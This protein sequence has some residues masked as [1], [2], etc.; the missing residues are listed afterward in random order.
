MR[1]SAALLRP[2]LVGLRHRATYASEHRAESWKPPPGFV[3]MEADDSFD[4][5]SFDDDDLLNQAVMTALVGAQ[6]NAV[7][8]GASL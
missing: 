4:G 1:P 5:G 3:D 7:E 2:P 8:G 6:G